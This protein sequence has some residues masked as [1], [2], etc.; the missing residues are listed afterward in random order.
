MSI[1]K[2]FVPNY[3]III[4]LTFLFIAYQFHW[5]QQLLGVTQPEE[6]S[7]IILVATAVLWIS[8]ALPLYITSLGVLFVQ[9]FWLLPALETAAIVA[10]KEDFLISFFGDI[11]LLFMGGFVLA[12]LLNKYGISRIIA[13]RIIQRTSDSPSLILL[14]IILVSSLLSMWMSNTATAAMMFAIMTPIVVSLPDTSKFSKAL[15]LAIPFA[16]NLGGIGTPIGTPPNAI[17]MEYLQQANVD[18]TFA[19]WMLIAIP[20][21]LVLLFLLWRVLL[22]D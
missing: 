9:L 6:I 1:R 10:K 20:L 22:L 2:V 11:T 17:A 5:F 4:T 21:M 8:E 18:I 19:M 12:A 13:R 15:A 3:G 7:I 16:C 14:S